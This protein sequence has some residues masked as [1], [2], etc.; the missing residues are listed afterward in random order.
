MKKCISIVPSE[1]RLLQ[2][3]LRRHEGQPARGLGGTT[4]RHREE[5]A[6]P[7][8]DAAAAEFGALRKRYT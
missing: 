7:I 1:R 5:W 8:V 6:A 2:V 3:V 4:R